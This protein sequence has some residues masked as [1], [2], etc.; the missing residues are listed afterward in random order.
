[1]SGNGGSLDVVGT[2]IRPGLQTTPEARALIEAASRVFYLLNDP[3]GE[4][5][6]R[7]TRSD[8]ESLASCYRE[9]AP[10]RE[11]YVEMTDRLLTAVR[12]GERV[13]AVFY[14]HPGVFVR[15]AHEAIRRA[16]QAGYAAYMCPGISAEDMLF[17]DVGFD[18]AETGCQ[19]HEATDFILEGRHFDSRSSLVLW[20]VGAIGD[21]SYRSAGYRSAGVNLLTEVLLRAYPPTHQVVVYEANELPLGPPRIDRLPLQALPEVPL[22][23]RSTLLVPPLEG[24]VRD[25]ELERRLEALLGAE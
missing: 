2:G 22:T 13:C 14:G 12:A 15:P 1:V 19:S 10:R 24:R 11:A 25:G 17:A 23:A 4:R 8:A 5:W 6:I 16:R 9:G 21:G 3:M 18:P 7:A 20:Q